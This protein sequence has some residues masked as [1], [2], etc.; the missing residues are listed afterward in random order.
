MNRWGIF[1]THIDISFV[2][3]LKIRNFARFFRKFTKETDDKFEKTIFDNAAVVCRWLDRG[4]GTDFG[5]GQRSC[6]VC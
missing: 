4:V 6:Y 1:Q 3:C 5:E 2:K